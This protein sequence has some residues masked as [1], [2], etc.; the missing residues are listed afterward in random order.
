MVALQCAPRL[1]DTENV[2]EEE[3]VSASQNEVQIGE[4]FAV[5]GFSSVEF[6]GEL[7]TTPTN[8]VTIAMQTSGRYSSDTPPPPATMWK[9]VASEVVSDDTPFVFQATE[10]ASFARVVYTSGSGTVGDL[11]LDMTRR[12]F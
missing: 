1:S 4:V 3:A 9:T 12:T 5:E 8:S 10:V 6:N 2:V 11:T 7:S